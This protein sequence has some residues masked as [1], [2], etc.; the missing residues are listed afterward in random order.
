MSLT[1]NTNISALEA[2]KTLRS[3]NTSLQK[4]LGRLSSG[5]GIEADTDAGGLAVSMKMQG[6]IQR[7][8]AVGKTIANAI[9][10]LQTQDGALS[11]VGN[12]VNRMSELKSLYDDITKE[13]PDKNAYQ[14]EYAE[15]QLQLLS[16]TAGKFN[17]VNLFVAA[18]ATADLTV[19]TSEDGSQ[20]VTVNQIGLVDEVFKATTS[21][22]DISAAATDLATVTITDLREATQALA[23]KRAGNGAQ[24]SRLQFA[25]D[26]LETTSNNLSAANSRILD[27]DVA[28]VSTEFAKFNILMQSGTAMLAQANMLPQLALRLLG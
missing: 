10:F 1:V 21:T 4:T 14:K 27:T 2:G 24:N 7:G 17:G 6:S 12:I 19:K 26:L 8:G 28:K 11:T 25:G 5:K 16:V 3:T 15:L 18:G 23:T 9:S 20:S 22:N 13:T